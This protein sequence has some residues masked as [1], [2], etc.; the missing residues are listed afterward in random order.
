[1]FVEQLETGNFFGPYGLVFSSTDHKLGYVDA[2]SGEV[3][4]IDE[5]GREQNGFPLPGNTPSSVG[6]LGNTSSFNLIT[7]GNDS[8]IY[9]YEL[10]R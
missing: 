5:K 1:M 2:A 4:L 9:N 10:K 7:G 3:H 8:F 6:K